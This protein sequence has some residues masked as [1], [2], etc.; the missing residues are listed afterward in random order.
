MPRLV[1]RSLSRRLP[2]GAAGLLVAASV[3]ASVG[4][5]VGASLAVALP[6]RAQSGKLGPAPAPL[7]DASYVA[8]RDSLLAHIDSGIV[9]VPGAREPV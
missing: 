6:L 8:R 1:I 9:V 7:A 4:A 5:S 2:S 3:A